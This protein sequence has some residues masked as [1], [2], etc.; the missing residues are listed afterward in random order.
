MSYNIFMFCL[1]TRLRARPPEAPNI[2]VATMAASLCHTTCW[3]NYQSYQRYHNSTATMGAAWTSAVTWAHPP[4][5]HTKA[6]NLYNINTKLKIMITCPVA[7]EWYNWEV[8]STQTY[9]GI[10]TFSTEYPPP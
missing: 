10:T 7:G 4:T 6:N 2:Q 5:H 9:M 8:A 1:D 3:P